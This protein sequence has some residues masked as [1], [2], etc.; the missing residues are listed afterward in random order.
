[1][2]ASNCNADKPR[3]K[4][5][6]V[7][8]AGW[9]RQAGSCISKIGLS[10]QIETYIIRYDREKKKSALYLRKSRQSHKQKSGCVQSTGQVLHVRHNLVQLQAGFAETHVVENVIFKDRR[11]KHR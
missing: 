8:G 11:V 7:R 5:T 4:S 2:V 1:M 6:E 9:K 10:V 3:T